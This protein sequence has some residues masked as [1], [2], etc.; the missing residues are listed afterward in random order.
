[1]AAMGIIMAAAMLLAGSEWG[2]ADGGDVFIQFN[3]GRVSG[4]GGCNR[5]S[6]SYEQDDGKLRLSQMISTQMA[7]T[8]DKVMQAEQH[9]LQMLD[10]VRQAD[11]THRRLIL[12]DGSGN[13]L[14]TL[15]RR[16]WD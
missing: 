15:V 1:M 12:K 11:A 16:D 6:G 14:A 4:S 7:C 13:A 5:F 9:F 3:D 10:A 8:D 2:F